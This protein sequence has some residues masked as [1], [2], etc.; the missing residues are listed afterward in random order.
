MWFDNLKE[1]R[2]WSYFNDISSIPRESGFENDIRKFLLRW[3]ERNGINAVADSIGNVIMKKPAS[4][5]CEDY[6]PVALQGHMDM[7]CVKRE[8]SEHNF[9]TDPIEIV[10][11]GKYISARDTS[12]GGD[13]GIAIATMLDI[14]SDDTLV[15]GPIECICTVN[16]EVGLTGAFGL[17]PK[18]IHARQLIN[19]DS[20]EEDIFYI[21]C[22]GGL[23]VTATRSV[24]KQRFDNSVY[25]AVDVEISGLLGGHSGGDIH[26]M[27]ANAIVIF[28]RYINQLPQCRFVTAR[29]GTKR[30]VIPSYLKATLLVCNIS[31]AIRVAEQLQK[32][33]RVEYC[34]SD[35]DITITV[36]ENTSPLKD[37]TLPSSVN[38]AIK[39]VI[40]CSPNGVIANSQTLPGLVETSCNLAILDIGYNKAQLVY[41]IRSSIE[42][43]KKNVAQTI[44]RLGESN[45][46]SVEIGDGYPGWIPNPD[47]PLTAKLAGIYEKYTGRKPEITAI[48]AGLECG[49]INSKIEGMD[50]V[51]IGPNMFDIHSVNE[52]LDIESAERLLGFL[53]TALKD[54]K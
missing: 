6:R 16:E 33:L 27:R 41:S 24:N 1:K 36:T 23:D 3:A 14:L 31:E 29:G 52:R 48:H 21:G 54:L 45:E 53:R 44:R 18:N 17:D 20:E 39:N 51:S 32:D 15:H 2:L 9:R 12:L 22:A 46:F 38:D 43:A 26:K 42:S 11:D 8:G 34:K 5:G 25:R 50:S 7:V 13:D 10:S 19:L 30:N 35:P 4:P 40:I 47:S 49:I 28:G 37:Y